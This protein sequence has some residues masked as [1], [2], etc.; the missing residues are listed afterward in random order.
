MRDKK[1]DRTTEN[2]TNKTTRAKSS[3]GSKV[4]KEKNNTSKKSSVKREKT[5]VEKN[6]TDEE[7][8][9]L[10]NEIES[11][12]KEK[13]FHRVEFKKVRVSVKAKDGTVKKEER[14][15]NLETG[16]Y[17][18]EEEY[19]NFL[20]EEN[21][22]EREFYIKEKSKGKRKK[23]IILAS[24]LCA[25]IVIAVLVKIIDKV[26]AVKTLNDILNKDYHKHDEIIIDETEDFVYDDLTYLD[27]EE[28]LDLFN[29]ASHKNTKELRYT[30]DNSYSKAK[31]S[32]DG[33][34]LMEVDSKSNKVEFVSKNSENT[35]IVEA[36]NFRGFDSYSDEAREQRKASIT[37]K[38]PIERKNLNEDGSDI[39]LVYDNG[40]RF[41]MIEKLN[42]ATLDSY[43]IL[44]EIKSN[45]DESEILGCAKNMYY[46]IDI[47]E[48]KEA[49]GK[50]EGSIVDEEGNVVNNTSTLKFIEKDGKLVPS[51]SKTARESFVYDKVKYSV[52]FKMNNLFLNGWT[53]RDIDI[54]DTIEFDEVYEAE[55][56][57]DGMKM[58]VEFCRPYIDKHDIR[59]KNDLVLEAMDYDERYDLR[60]KEAIV[61]KV[62]VSDG[63]TESFYMCGSY[64]IGDS[65]NE[66]LKEIISSPIL[67]IELDVDYKICRATIG[68]DGNKY[69]EDCINSNEYISSLRRLIKDTVEIENPEDLMS[70]EERDKL[71]TETDA[72]DE[73][74]DSEEGKEEKVD[75][76][77]KEVRGIEND[78]GTFTVETATGK[79]TYINKDI[80]TN[81]D[82]LKYYTTEYANM[83]A[84]EME[85]AIAEKDIK[86]LSPYEVDFYNVEGKSE[87]EI[88]EYYRVE[89]PKKRKEYMD[90]TTREQRKNNSIKYLVGRM[91]EDMQLG[92]VTD[93]GTVISTKVAG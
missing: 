41:Y 56:E 43:T 87:E 13:E 19:N 49:I 50:L 31:V 93:S 8:D 37:G 69:I 20:E 12:K 57:K 33:D 63:D 84:E 39:L 11:K 54:N 60:A 81:E 29:N 16:A 83:T 15:K 30:L 9:F 44:V 38:K 10:A 47:E 74:E 80:L 67:E 14:Y 92:Q 58:K 79:K 91:N 53:S 72:E 64:Q 18:K 46:T 89:L 32:V 70:E 66:E 2:K 77:D 4:M 23:T 42:E 86:D 90:S 73:E 55:F 88:D 25:V 17:L 45:I 68:I 6:L 27:A 59:V 48:D 76:G 62:E 65:F 36:N 34:Y 5:K 3:S 52:P 21:L 1:L 78:D 26:I 22:R 75:T 35:I 61:N 82:V 7:I 24:I 85:V 51:I 28:A 40:N 71:D